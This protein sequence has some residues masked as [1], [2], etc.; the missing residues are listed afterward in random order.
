VV[1]RSFLKRISPGDAV[2]L[3]FVYFYLILALIIV[4]YPIIYVISSSFS[5]PTAVNAGQVVLFPVDFS[6][7]GY[8]RT[9]QNKQV[10]TGLYN[11]VINTALYA[12]IGTVTTI[13]GA[14]PLSRLKFRGR[15]WVMRFMVFTMLFSGGL[16]PLYLVVKSAGLIDTRWSLIFPSMMSVY[17]AIITRTYFTTTIPNELYESSYI[18]G[19]NEFQILWKVVIPLSSPIL[20]VLG[21]MYAISQW[22]SYFSALI[23]LQSQDLYPLQLVLRNILLVNGM[24]V[25]SV[26]DLKAMLE[27]EGMRDLLKY[28]LIVISSVPV[29]VVYPFV[30]KYFIKGMMLGAVKG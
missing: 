6:T 1:G 13:L 21:L 18:D 26:A 22:N 19:C 29:L 17:M 11:T 2:F 4:L 8:E 7:T 20:A 5:S 24:S 12:F 15:N 23:Y 10:F 30:Q 25:S 28:S 16:I 14:Y 3:F 27:L 9:F